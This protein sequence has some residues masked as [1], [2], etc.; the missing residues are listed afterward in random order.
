M[1]EEFS[2]IEKK[3]KPLTKGNIVARNLEDDCAFFKKLNNLVVSVDNSIE[4]VHVPF[5]TDEKIQSRRAV[6]RA[7][8]DIATF[9]AKPICIFSSIMMPINF[10]NN[11]F[12]KIALGFKEALIEYDMFL[13]GGDT[14]KY[15]GPLS[16]SITVLG[17]HGINNLGRSGAKKGDLIIVSGNI[18]SAFI[19]LKLLN[20]EISQEQVSNYSHLIDKFLVPYPRIS[21]GKI[22]SKFST[23]MIDIS[24]GLISDLQHLCIQSKLGAKINLDKIPVKNDIKKLLNLELF[25]IYD[26]ITAGDDYELI[27]T[28]DPKDS[29]NLDNDSYII[30][31]MIEDSS[32]CI[33]D[34][35]GK[36]IAPDKDFGGYKH[37]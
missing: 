1:Y 19:G 7:L 17:E 9:G 37:F 31:E 27:Y 33:I 6:L 29:N 3:L 36:I 24:D 2:F 11:I 18:G 10:K 23:S 28:I 20:K 26:L 30:G 14:A 5:G 25:N 4:G 12:D 13:A 21:L 15:N 32:C 22:I 34:E 16:F 8:S 35:N